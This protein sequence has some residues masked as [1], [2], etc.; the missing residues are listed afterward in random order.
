MRKSKLNGRICGIWVTE[1]LEQAFRAKIA[2]LKVR[3]VDAIRQAI[4]EYTAKPVPPVTG[5][6]A[7]A[8]PPPTPV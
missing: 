2:A 8:E 7:Q 1:E 6:Q 4:A 3:P 5:A